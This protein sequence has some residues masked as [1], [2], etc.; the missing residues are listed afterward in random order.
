MRFKGLSSLLQKVL[1][2]R[3]SGLLK[4]VLAGAGLTFGSTVVMTSLVDS[5]VSSVKSNVNSIPA[6]VLTLMG[7][8]NIDYAL[9]VILSA[10]VSRTAMNSMGIFLKQKK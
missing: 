7:M 5:Y 1:E 8:S 4:N 6:D 9:S 3:E 2:S 10:I